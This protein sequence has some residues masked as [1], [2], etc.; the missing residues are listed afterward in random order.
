VSAVK[1]VAFSAGANPHICFFTNLGDFLAAGPRIVPF[2]NDSPNYIFPQWQ[3]AE[4]PTTRLSNVIKAVL[5]GGTF[6]TRATGVRGDYTAA[7]LRVGVVNFLMAFMPAELVAYLTG[8]QL[9]GIGALFEYLRVEVCLLSLSHFSNQFCS[10]SNESV[11]PFVL[12]LHHVHADRQAHARHDCPRWISSA[13][14]G[15]DGPWAKASDA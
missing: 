12:L 13:S 8:H 14:V 2:S 4:S 7:S 5:E 3:A 15:A 10:S 1:T 6:R 11:Y 9:T